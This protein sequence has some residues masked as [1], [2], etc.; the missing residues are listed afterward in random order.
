MYYSKTTG[1]FYARELHTSIPTDAVEITKAEW[2]ELLAGQSRGQRIVADQMG[3]PVLANAPETVVGPDDVKAEANRRISAVM[4][5]WVV[6]REVSGGAPIP[7]DIKTFAQ[8]VREASD[9]LE[10]MDPIPLDYADNKW[11]PVLE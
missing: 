2:R 11:W 5:D 9:V 10:E 4:P 3:R 8:K 1:G 6:A 7:D